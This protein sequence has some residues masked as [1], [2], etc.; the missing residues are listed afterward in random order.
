MFSAILS[1]LFD[2]V[3]GIVF[4]GDVH[5]FGFMNILNVIINK[6]KY[7]VRR[8]GKTPTNSKIKYLFILKHSYATQSESKT[9][10]YL[11]IENVPS[12]SDM[13]MQCAIRSST[14]TNH[15]SPISYLRSLT[16]KN[17]G[18]LLTSSYKFN[19]TKHLNN[20]KT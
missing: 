2:A 4:K 18:I 16:Y 13:E 15:S 9:N 19:W 10:A 17:I 7:L 14:N 12:R 20:V 3:V 1:R 8:R 11:T 5:G 6:F